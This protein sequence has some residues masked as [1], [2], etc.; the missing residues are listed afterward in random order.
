MGGDGAEYVVR[1]WGGGTVTAQRLSYYSPSEMPVAT[2]MHQKKNVDVL[3]IIQFDGFDKELPT[4]Q[5]CIRVRRRKARYKIA[6]TT[7]IGLLLNNF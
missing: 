7:S 3:I 5:F 4:W 1:V 6:V 2:E